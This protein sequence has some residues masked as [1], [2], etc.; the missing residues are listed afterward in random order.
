MKFRRAH[1]DQKDSSQVV[2]TPTDM[3]LT[4][5]E[6]I[7]H[8]T[9]EAKKR[10]RDR[11]APSPDTEDTETK[12]QMLDTTTEPFDY[13]AFDDWMREMVSGNGSP[14]AIVEVHV[15]GGSCTE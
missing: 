11:D 12:K 5:I 9:N 6:P 10:D 4:E 1:S 8:N 7:F 15:S 2:S 13:S 14:D 3:D